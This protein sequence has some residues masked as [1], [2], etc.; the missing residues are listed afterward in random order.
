[1]VKKKV[2]DSSYDYLIDKRITEVVPYKRYRFENEEYHVRNVRSEKDMEK[3]DKGVLD[4]IE[5]MEGRSLDAGTNEMV[6]I[7]RQK[8]KK[9]I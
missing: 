3:I 9:V 4:F 8:L 7:K 6:V 1:M 2:H 5:V